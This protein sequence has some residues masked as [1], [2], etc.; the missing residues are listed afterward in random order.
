MRIW[1]AG[2]IAWDSVLYVNHLPAV[3]GFTHAKKHQERPGGQA[4]N[5]AIALKESGFETGLVGY[6][7]NDQFGKDL[8][9]FAK[10]KLDLVEIKTINHPTP[11]VTIIVDAN[12]ERTMIGMEQSFF[13]EISLNLDVI[14]SEDIVVWPIWREA[15]AIDFAAVKAKGCRTIVGLGALKCSI[16]ADIALG[17]KWELPPDFEAAKYLKSFLRIIVTDNQNGAIEYSQDAILEAPAIKADAVDTTGAGDAFL[18]GV[19]KGF[20]E[21]L[22]NEETLKIASNWAALAIAEESSIPPKFN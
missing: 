3:G 2:P 4:L 22:P 16:T 7:G 17:S 12:G 20:A 11:H 10:S 13:S 21:Q 8:I 14:N 18:C 19:I 15:F 6:V 5:V 9:N 1:I